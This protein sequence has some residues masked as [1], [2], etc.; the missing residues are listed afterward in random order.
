M[1]SVTL[2]NGVTLE[3][4]ERGKASGVP[5]IFLHGVTDSGRAFEPVLD[6][7]PDTIH[8]WLITQRGHGGSSKPDEGYTYAD[9]AEDVRAF[10]DV[11]ELPSAVIV[12][13][14]MGSLVAQ[15]FAASHPDRV[16]GLVLMG[17]FR[18]ICNDPGIQEFWDSTLSTLT[19]P[20]DAA[21]ARDFQVSTLAR[22]VPPEFLEMVIGESLRV[23]ARVWRATFKGFL[24]TPDFSGELA[25]LTVPALIVWGDRDRYAR[26][27]DQDALREAIPGSRLIVYPGAGHAFHWEDPARFV[28]DLIAFVYERPVSSDHRGKRSGLSVNSA[29]TFSSSR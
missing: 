15:R 14:S 2:P 25:R 5:M 22:P 21:L 19:D 18:T 17:A 26:S 23:P 27:A 13:H 20:V 3:Y 4:V 6:R 1:R 10:M 28:A 7:L 8:A 9:M 16:A 24:E 12:G 29:S 11:F